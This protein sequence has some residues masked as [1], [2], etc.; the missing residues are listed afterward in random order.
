MNNNEKEIKLKSRE[1]SIVLWSEMKLGKPLD[2]NLFCGRQALIIHFFRPSQKTLSAG[3]VIYDVIMKYSA[4]PSMKRKIN[5]KWFFVSEK[6][7]RKFLARQKDFH[8]ISNS[9]FPF[10]IQL[11]KFYWYK[12]NFIKHKW[13]SSERNFKFIIVSIEIISKGG[14]NNE[15]MKLFMKSSN[16]S[17]SFSSLF[18]A[19]PVF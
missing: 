17:F 11:L 14:F 6:F 1:I 9:W 7:A 2:G 4:R 13:K 18:H 15:L 3:K 19:Q 12:L 16:K 10:S 5:G 8:A